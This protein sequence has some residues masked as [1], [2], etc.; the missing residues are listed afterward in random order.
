MYKIYKEKLKFKTF[1]PVQK[2]VFDIYKK[3][4]S[5][6]AIAPTGTGKTHAYGIPVIDSI[7]VSIKRLQSIIL[8]P[9]NELIRQVEV[10]LSKL[11][12]FVNIYSIT[13]LDELKRKRIDS[14]QLIITTPKKIMKLIN[15][16]LLNIKHLKNVV[17][18]EADMMFEGD[19]ISDLNDLTSY[20][21]K[22]RY[23]LF[24]ASLK[25]NMK[26][27]INNFFG[28]YELIDT[29]KDHKLKIRDL[30]VYSREETK[31]YN[32]Y[33]I[34]KSLNPF[35][36][37]IFV[38]KK[39]NINLI[40][41]YLLE[42]DIKVNTFSSDL[43]LRKR[44][45]ML[46]SARNYSFQWLLSSDILSR[47]IDL[48]ISLIINYDFPDNIKTYF[49]RRG[50]TGRMD[51]EGDVISIYGEKDKELIQKLSKQGIKILKAKIVNDNLT[52]SPQKKQMNSIKRELKIRNPIKRPKYSKI[53]LKRGLKK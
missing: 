8:V 9:T 19:F 34:I 17:L 29:T 1:T 38:S 12:Q 50:R 47:G 32:L 52:V 22:V 36:G 5:I 40:K 45:S 20:I 23:L 15:S 48:E 24:S 11:N 51:N 26:P 49:H 46:K 53:K 43:K 3:Q 39:N 35:F 21:S 37:V 25:R 16:N 30:F 33:K 44:L 41:D 6:V 27:F 13:G 4:K 31:L 10:M 18:D 28:V 14:S 42:K 2:K 7:D